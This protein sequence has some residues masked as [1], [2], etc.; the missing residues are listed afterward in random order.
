MTEHV[1]FSGNILIY[2][3]CLTDSKSL[4]HHNKVSRDSSGWPKAA[5]RKAGGRPET[6]SDEW[7]TKQR[8][9]L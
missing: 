9:E 1:R 4:C 2:L 3:K 6:I 5:S 8:N 7:I